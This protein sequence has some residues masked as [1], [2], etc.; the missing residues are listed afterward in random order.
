[1]TSEKAQLLENLP[2]IMKNR[3]NSEKQ[4][5][6]KKIG[7]EKSK[8]ANCPKHVLPKLRAD[9][10]HVHRVRGRRGGIREV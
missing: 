3:K 4:I 1:M 10:S 8:V 7:A 6:K 5:P 9:R 2:K